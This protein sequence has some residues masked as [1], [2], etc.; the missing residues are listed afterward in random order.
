M[1][2]EHVS[3]VWAVYLLERFFRIATQRWRVLEESEKPRLYKK[4][5]DLFQFL[6]RHRKGAFIM[7]FALFIAFIERPLIQLLVVRAD[8]MAHL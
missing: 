7:N 1:L 2:F 8:E 5:R 6:L 4:V 3:L